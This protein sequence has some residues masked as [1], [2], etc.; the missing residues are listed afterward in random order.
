M[1][2]FTVLAALA[3]ALASPAAASAPALTFQVSLGPQIVARMNAV[4]ASHGLR[5]LRM[6]RGLRAAARQHSVEM[7]SKGYFDH[8]SAN[9]TAFWKR[10]A[11]FYGSGGYRYWSVGENLYY[12]SPDT[13]AAST[14]SAW[15]HSPEH[16]QN[17]LT[18]E[19]RDVGV[20]AVHAVGASGEYAGYPV[21]IVTVDFGVRY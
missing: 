14:L 7:A 12:E 15:M 5:P 13:T 3:A 17:I 11:R 1:R 9:G 21:T 19:W 6:S 2:R 4:R 20:S 10:I 8:S 16:R 18:R